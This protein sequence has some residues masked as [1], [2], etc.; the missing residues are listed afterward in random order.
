MNKLYIKSVVFSTLF[1]SSVAYYYF[2]GNIHKGI[3]TPR[4]HTMQCDPNN[5]CI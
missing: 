1:I 4:I 2:F 5:Y 3:H